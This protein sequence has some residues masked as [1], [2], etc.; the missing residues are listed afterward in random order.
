M[1]PRRALFLAVALALAGVAALAWN[2]G[3]AAGDGSTYRLV[4]V[5]VTGEGPNAKA[6]YDGAPPAGAPVQAA[7]DRFAQDGFKF[8]GIVS[9][10]RAGQTVVVTSPTVPQTDQNRDPHLVIL[11]ERR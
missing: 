10:G 4:Y 1:S 8:A 2:H 9:G 6:W 11:L 5:S 7:L 3:S